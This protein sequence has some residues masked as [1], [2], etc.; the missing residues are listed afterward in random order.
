MTSG[1]LEEAMAVVRAFVLG[2]ITTVPGSQIGPQ[3]A[4]IRMKANDVATNAEAL[5]RLGTLINGNDIGTAMWDVVTTAI[6]CG[7]TFDNMYR[8]LVET[9]STQT[10]G[11]PAQ[12]CQDAAIAFM[13][14][15][16][17]L[18]TAATEFTSREDVQTYVNRLV[19]GFTPAIEELAD[20]GDV[21][22][23]RDMVALQAYCIHDLAE[24]ARPLPMMIAYSI[25][26]PWPALR[27][28][29]YLYPE[30]TRTKGFNTDD[31]VTELIE[32]NKI[33]HPAFCPTQG[34]ALTAS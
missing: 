3:A 17:V 2:L 30:S 10:N 9:R 33:V 31:R 21:M 28:A 15:A 8:V 20:V 19:D 5:V 29:N 34:R 22:N 32:E 4:S 24:R 12:F 7:A 11:L 16:L 6:D 14:S 1:E 18:I 23:Y 25:T 27:L 13:L 26:D